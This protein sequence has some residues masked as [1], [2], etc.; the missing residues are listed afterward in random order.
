MKDAKTI[1]GVSVPLTE[2]MIYEEDLIEKL[3]NYRPKDIVAD[4]D[5]FEKNL[6]ERFR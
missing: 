2:K 5:Y 4:L 6:P 3:V 1:N